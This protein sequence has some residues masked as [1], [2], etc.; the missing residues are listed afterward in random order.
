[1]NTLENEYTV[2]LHI[3]AMVRRMREQ[4]GLT[5]HQLGQAIGASRQYISMIEHGRQSC[6]IGLLAKIAA[7]LDCYLDITLTKK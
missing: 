7:A 4:K 5:Q 3:G 6:S 1:M 2:L